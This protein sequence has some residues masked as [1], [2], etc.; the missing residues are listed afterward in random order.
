MTDKISNFK[1]SNFS[2]NLTGKSFM[3]VVSFT[4][5]LMRMAAACA[6]YVSASIL[7]PIIIAGVIQMFS[8]KEI[9]YCA[10]GENGKVA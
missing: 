6:A 5:L 8:V 3:F 4:A 9:N 7:W 1:P 10:T 2:T